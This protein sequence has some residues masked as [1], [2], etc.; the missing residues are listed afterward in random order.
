[1]STDDQNTVLNRSAFARKST[2]STWSWPSLLSLAALTIGFLVL[3][4]VLAAPFISSIL[5]AI[6]LAVVLLPIQIA[7]ERRTRKKGLAAFATVLVV[8]FLVAVPIFLLGQ[9]VVSEAANVARTVSKMASSGALTTWLEVH[10]RVADAIVW[11]QSHIDIPS[12]TAR[13]SGTI[14]TA[15]PSFLQ[16]SGAGLVSLVISIYFLFYMLRDRHRALGVTRILIPLPAADMSILVSRI[17]DTIRGTVYGTVLVSVI[18]GC[19][20]GTMLWILGV[21]GALLWGMV[22]GVAA[23]V[24]MLGTFVVWAPAAVFLALSGEPV[25]AAIL[26]AWSMFIVSTI[27]NLLYPLLVGNRLKMH[28]VPTFISLIGGVVLLGPAGIVFGP[29]ILTITIFLLEFWHRPAN[30]LPLTTERD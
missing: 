26:V 19:L 21:P 30:D 24:P 23:I 14:A 4:Y 7:F 9:S 3:A 28:T 6:A 25:K 17:A 8:I 5:S 20:G 11:V 13:A 27:D 10:P 12:I 16:G 2:D 29:V 22:M 18:Q 1:M 15:V